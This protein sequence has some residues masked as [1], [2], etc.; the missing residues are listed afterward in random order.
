VSTLERSGEAG[1]WRRS[2]MGDSSRY[3]AL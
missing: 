2:L 1:L 3:P